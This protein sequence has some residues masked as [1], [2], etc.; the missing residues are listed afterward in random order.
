LEQVPPELAGDALER[1]LV[2]CGGGARLAGLIER[3][4]DATGLPVVLA[5]DPE[6]CAL[7]G[8]GRRR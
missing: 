7:S 8:R 4:R 2:L 6:R 1:G 5:E 3:L